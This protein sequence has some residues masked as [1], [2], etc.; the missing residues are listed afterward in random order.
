[1]IN[2]SVT[3]LL[4]KVDNRYRLVTVTAKRARQIINNQDFLIETGDRDKPLT[5]A[6]DEVNDGLVTYE[7]IVDSFK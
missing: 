2:P 5:S 4:E 6:I 3:D 1:M 7:T